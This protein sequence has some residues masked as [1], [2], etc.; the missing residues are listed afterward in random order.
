MRILIV[1]DSRAVRTR[2]VRLLS[3]VE[4]VEVVGQ[5]AEAQTAIASIQELKPEVVV[6]DLSLPDGSGLD[7]LKVFPV[8]TQRPQFLVFTNWATAQHRRKCLEAGAAHFFDKAHDVE[9]LLDV[10][11]AMGRSNGHSAGKPAPAGQQ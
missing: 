1:D 6:L 2:M 4:G 11:A 5:A 8:N 10:V 7:V 3:G 9:R